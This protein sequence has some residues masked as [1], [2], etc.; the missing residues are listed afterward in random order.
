VNLGF[1][2]TRTIIV[3]SCASVTAVL[4]I[5]RDLAPAFADYSATLV[6]VVVTI[7]A[8]LAP[9][10]QPPK[11]TDVLDQAADDLTAALVEQWREEEAV[12]GIDPFPLPVRLSPVS[13]PDLAGVGGTCMVDPD[14]TFTRISE[15]LTSAG[16]SKGLVVL[17]GVGAG[18]SALLLR[19]TL[20][21]LRNRSGGGLGSTRRSGGLDRWTA[22]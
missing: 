5:I 9:T 2:G 21:L 1:R 7:I 3:V 17:G 6:S 15:F 13:D 18:K 10:N 8:I 16:P 14:G 4:W 11:L 22:R 12:R 19:L 20:D